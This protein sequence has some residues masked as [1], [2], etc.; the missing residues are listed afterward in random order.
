M[1]LRLRLTLLYTTILAVTLASFSAA[2]YVIQAQVTLD[3]LHASLVRSADYLAA[4]PGP[5]GPLGTPGVYNTTELYLQT[6][7]L[8][9]RLAARSDNLAGAELPL[10]AGDL[11]AV[12]AGGQTHH[13]TSLLGDE[14]LVHNRPLE[15]RGQ[16]VGVLQ[17]A[18]S[19][20]ERNQSLLALRR[21][22]LLGNATAILVAGLA[23]WAAA[24]LAL[25]PIDR[26]TKIARRIGAERDFG[27]R[28]EHTGPNDEIGR[29]AATF[30]TMLAELQSAHLATEQ[31]L[32]AQ[33]R[34]VADA[35]HELRTPLTT[36]L[37]NL[38]LLDRH[39]PISEKDRREVLADMT[40]EMERLI[41]LVND[42]LSL[43]RA[44]AHRTLL[45]EAVPLQPL[46]SDLHRQSRLLA[47]DRRID[48]SAPSGLAVRG[49]R[50]AVKQIVL[51]LLD[52]AFKH[53]PPA[54]SVT[55][56]AE[57]AANG[58]VALRVADTG[59]GIAPAALPNLFDRFFRA[60]ASRASPGTGLGLP[61]AKML[62]EAQG[63]SI[64][65]ASQP[66]LG[67]TF[68]VILPAA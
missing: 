7:S 58:Q 45:S 21:M 31:A 57:P 61:I 51:I 20:A 29:L 3:A 41:R 32:Q 34:F 5:G 37:G 1:S 25:H 4:R 42:L 43:A 50:D 10:S 55:V 23:G 44:D 22:L 65:V 46:L 47:P 15:S 66:G 2:L 59:P 16:I 54:A 49:D 13:Q 33:R 64:T 67:S 36:L 30:N 11:G 24:G 28:V 35:S 19:L 18:R 68:T 6:R 8:D 38:G 14:L 17:V 12:A 48:C 56:E 39:P 9:G 52:N 26:L 63:G 62:A 27:R 60:D 40:D 53:T